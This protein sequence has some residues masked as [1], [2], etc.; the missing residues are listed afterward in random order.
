MDI[1]KRFGMSLMF[2]SHNLGVVRHVSDHIAVMYM[3]RIV[4]LATENQLFEKP[5]HPYTQVLISA[6]PE[7]NP[8]YP[9]RKNLLKGEIPSPVD[10]PSGCHF[11]TRCP[12]AEPECSRIE[13]EFQETASGRW[14]RCHFPGKTIGKEF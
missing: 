7:A 12:V 9:H 4:E 6:V 1:Q 10:P 5:L 13:P 2:I 14:V 3:G 8:A 11:H